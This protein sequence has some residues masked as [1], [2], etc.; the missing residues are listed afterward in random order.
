MTKRFLTAILDV[1]PRFGPRNLALLV[2]SFSFTDGQDTFD[3]TNGAICE[4]VAKHY[5]DFVH[6]E[7]RLTHPLRRTG[8]R[9]SGRFERIGWDEALDRVHDGIRAARHS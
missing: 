3:S 9:G 1:S 8:P 7:K 5:P 4:K 2:E 6:G